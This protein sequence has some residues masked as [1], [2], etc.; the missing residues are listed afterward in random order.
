LALFF[1]VL[2][3][4]EANEMLGIRRCVLKGMPLIASSFALGS[5]TFIGPAA[6][7]NVREGQRIQLVVFRHMTQN[8]FSSQDAR[9]HRFKYLQRLRPSAP[10]LRRVNKVSPI[11]DMASEFK[12]ALTYS[13][14]PALSKRLARMTRTPDPKHTLKK[15]DLILEVGQIQWD[16]RNQAVVQ[17]YS[18]Y[19]FDDKTQGDYGAGAAQGWS[20]RL[21]KVQGQWR[22]LGRQ[23]NFAAG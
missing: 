1:T 13:V 3:I 2:V 22:V 19:T 11:Q 6:P 5:L 18:Q 20:Y 15:G 10:A 7:A 9:N 4:W 14:S 8:S 16:G 23:S 21:Q 12:D 17:A